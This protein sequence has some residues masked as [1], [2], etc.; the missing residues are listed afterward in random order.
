M[1]EAAALLDDAVD[2]GEAEAGSR[3]GLL[4]GEERFEDAGL[5]GGFHTVAGV[6]NGD[7]HVV[8]TLDRRMEMGVLAVDEKILR[9]D[10][11]LAAERHGV[12]GVDGEIE[13]DLLELA[14]V[15]FDAAEGIAEAQA[16]FD[17]LADQAAEELAHIGDKFVEVED[18]WLK[19]LHAAE[20]EHLA[21]EGSGTV[22]RFA[23]LLA[24]A[25]EGIFRLQAV[26]E[27]VAVAA[28]YGKQV[29]EVVGYAAGHTAE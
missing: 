25:V 28:D 11:E 8:S 15:G 5:G 7:D 23:N 4:G 6:G 19:D 13:E 16:E 22:G 3:A 14:G 10:G 20:C 18:L 26:E 29:V 1:D 24:T 21:G 12:A 9:I 2:G 27:Q 17:V